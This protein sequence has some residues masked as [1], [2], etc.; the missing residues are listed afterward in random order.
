M[1]AQ[2]DPIPPEPP[3][4][5]AS[6]LQP[7]V[8]FSVDLSRQGGG[9]PVQFGPSGTAALPCGPMS[10]GP[11][12]TLEEAL[13]NIRL[14]CNPAT[15]EWEKAQF[16]RPGIDYATDDQLE[17][18]NPNTNGCGWTMFYDPLRDTCL[19]YGANRPNIE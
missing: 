17:S 1:G 2:T 19:S 8:P 7:T 13:S 18:G 14:V 16:A 15:G 11:G 4:T 9:T 6:N 3:I 12:L 10:R 5:L